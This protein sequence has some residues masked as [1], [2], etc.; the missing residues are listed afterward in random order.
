MNIYEGKIS[1]GKQT[2]W[3]VTAAGSPHVAVSQLTKAASKV[4]KL[5]M[6]D[7]FVVRVRVLHKDMDWKTFIESGKHGAWMNAPSW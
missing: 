4:N 2:I 6:D 7:G 1:N 5:N 3:R